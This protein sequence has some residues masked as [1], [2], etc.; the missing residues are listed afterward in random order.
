ML[1]AYGRLIGMYPEDVRFAYG[2]E[3][4]ADLSSGD[5]PIVGDKGRWLSRVRLRP[6]AHLADT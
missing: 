6:P 2:K 1:R 5:M 3:M 4:P